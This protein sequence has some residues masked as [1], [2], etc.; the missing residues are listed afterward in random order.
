M[1]AFIMVTLIFNMYVDNV[2]PQ[3]SFS[4]IAVEDSKEWRKIW[5]KLR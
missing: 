4:Y 2:S 1:R 3:R 5:K